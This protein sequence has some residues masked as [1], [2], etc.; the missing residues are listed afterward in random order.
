MSSE[1]VKF[2]IYF[3]NRLTNAGICVIIEVEMGAVLV[4]SKSEIPN[5]ETIAAIEE[6]RR[7][8]RDKNVRGYRTIEALKTALFTDDEAIREKS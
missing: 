4:K 5:D 1:C 8:A 6:G 7:I 2:A 3:S